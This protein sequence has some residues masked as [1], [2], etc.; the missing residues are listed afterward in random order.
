[1]VSGTMTGP[2]LLVHLL[3]EWFGVFGGPGGS[4]LGGGETTEAAVGTPGVVFDPPVF[5]D[6]SG[7]LCATR[8]LRCSTVR[9][10]PVR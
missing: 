10:G 6:D 8:T 4:V 2:R 7:F 9:L 3:W 5:D 1:M